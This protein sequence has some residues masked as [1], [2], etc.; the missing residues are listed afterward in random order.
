MVV[1][2]G[3]AVVAFVFVASASAASTCF[4]DPLFRS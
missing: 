1:V 4:A 2:G 3:G